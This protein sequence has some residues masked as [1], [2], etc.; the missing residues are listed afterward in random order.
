LLRYF[1]GN[2]GDDE[3]AARRAQR[4]AEEE[5]ERARKQAEKDARNAAKKAER[6]AE[7][8]AKNSVYVND[9]RVYMPHERKH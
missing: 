8:D 9:S 4:V 1:P 5:A 2:Q 7:N 3:K 6:E